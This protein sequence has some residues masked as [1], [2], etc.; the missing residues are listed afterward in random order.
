MK[1][2]DRHF[3]NPIRHSFFLCDISRRGMTVRGMTRTRGHKYSRVLVPAINFLVW[4]RVRALCF[5]A[6]QRATWHSSTY[7]LLVHEM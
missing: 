5:D 4:C 1:V 6:A 3:R 7:I 2:R